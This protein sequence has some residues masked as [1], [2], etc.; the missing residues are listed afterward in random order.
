MAEA[1]VAKVNSAS[2]RPSS[3]TPS[4]I[5]LSIS[6]THFTP[7]IAWF[8]QSTRLNQAEHHKGNVGSSNENDGEEQRCTDRENRVFQVWKGL[9]EAFFE[10]AFDNLLELRPDNLGCDQHALEDLGTAVLAE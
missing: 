2:E 9:W 10:H 3:T 5:S 7:T 6:R 8:P 1:L 4:H